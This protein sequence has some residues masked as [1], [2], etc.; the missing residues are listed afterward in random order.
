MKYLTI[1]FVWLLLFFM[2]TEIGG[3][4]VLLNSL[5]K[6][7]G[8]ALVLAFWSTL[9]SAVLAAVWGWYIKRKTS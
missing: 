2:G 1:C 3:N 8:E 7:G 6:L 9:G 5:P 4:P